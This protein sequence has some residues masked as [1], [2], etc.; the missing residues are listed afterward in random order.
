MRLMPWLY[1]YHYIIP[2]LLECS[3]IVPH[4]HTHRHVIMVVLLSALLNEL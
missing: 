4:L 3:D 1:Q 2:S